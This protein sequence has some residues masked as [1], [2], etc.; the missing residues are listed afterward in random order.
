MHL[1]YFNIVN[2]SR[3][4]KSHL[5]TASLFVYCSLWQYIKIQCKTFMGTNW[6]WCY[7]VGLTVHYALTPWSRDLLDKLTSSQLVKKFLTFYEKWRSITSFTIACH[8]SLP[9]DRSIQSITP[10]PNSHFLII[11]LHFI[12]PSMLGSSKWSFPSSFPTKTPYT[13]LLPPYPCMLHPQPISFFSIL[14]PG[15]YLVRTTDH[16]VVFS[17][18][19]LP[20]PS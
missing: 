2:T 1:V 17:I 4:F 13:P 18:P 16:Y 5:H 9:E 11:H 3:L 15:Q 10:P 8:L 14:S 20:H 19:S 6:K 12:L 7:N